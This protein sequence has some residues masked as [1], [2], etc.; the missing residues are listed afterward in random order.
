M[1]GARNNGAG[2]RTAPS[3]GATY[4][5]EVYAAVGEVAGRDPGLYRYLPQMHSLEAVFAGDLRDQ[6][7]HAAL[8]QQ[9]VRDAPVVLVVTAVPA[10]TERR[11]GAR[12][13]R[14]VA[15]EAGHASQNIY[16]QATGLEL[17]TVAIGAFDDAA[18]SSAL[19]LTDGEQ[20]FYLMPVGRR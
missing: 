2:Y 18:L 16:L 4:P 13:V 8:R 14:Y 19:E 10:R 7:Y 6:L 3:A 9:P 12:A 15:M 1:G 20:P 11:Y 5:L 17:G